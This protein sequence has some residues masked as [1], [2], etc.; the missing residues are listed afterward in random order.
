MPAGSA[1]AS[2]TRNTAAPA[3]I[4]LYAGGT[5]EVRFKDVSL[6][7]PAAASRAAGAGLAALPDAGAQRVLLLVG[8]RR[9]RHQQGRRLPTS[10]PG[11]TTTSAPTT[12]SRARFTWPQTIDASTKYFNGVQFAYDFTGDGW[13]DVINCL[14]TQPTIALRQPAR[15]SRGAGTA[16]RSPTASAARSRCSRTSTATASWSTSSRTANNQFVYASPDPAN[17]TGT[18]TTQP[19]STTAA[20]GP[21]TAWASATSTATAASI[22]ERIRLVGAASEGDHQGPGPIILAP[23][24]TLE[25][26]EPW[27]RRDWRL[28][29][30]RRRTER[31]VTSLQAHGWGLSWFEQKKAGDGA[32][33]FVEHP[34]MGDFSTKNAGNV[35]FSELH[36]IDRRR[37]RR[38]RHQGLRHRQA[39]LVAPRHLPRSRSARRAGALRLPDGAQS[40]GAGRRRVRARAGPQPIGHRLATRRWSI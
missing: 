35:T 37:H 11:R 13:P 23:F 18:W 25:S 26:L 5:G 15:A 33:S 32:I 8:P 10:S 17:P 19:L 30:Q 34:I 28:R 36:G 4:A 16:S 27:R 3:P 14:F 38:R 7:G 22:C 29:R 31:L 12:T 6:Q 1:A 20:R 39:L 9:R 2:P 40:E 21:I 24:G